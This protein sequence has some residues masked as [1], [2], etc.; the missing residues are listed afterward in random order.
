MQWTISS[1]T[2]SLNRIE[3]LSSKGEINEYEVALRE[4]RKRQIRRM[5]RALGHTV[6]HL[7]RIQEGSLELGDLKPGA[8]RSLDPAEVQRLREEVYLT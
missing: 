6:T 1:G 7:C 2:L 5:F 4:G 3:I 8:W